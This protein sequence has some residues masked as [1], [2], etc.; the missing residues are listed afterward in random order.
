MAIAPVMLVALAIGAYKFFVQRSPVLAGRDTVVVA[1]FA[2]STG[3]PVFESTLRQ[4][5]SVQME[6][7]PFLT[8]I[9]DG[10]WVIDVH[11]L[12]P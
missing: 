4:G 5:L 8:Q 2:N 6:Q 10:R 3:D 12:L 1:D 9:S 11:T 7:S